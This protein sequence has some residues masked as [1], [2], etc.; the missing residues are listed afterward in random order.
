VPQCN[1]RVCRWSDTLNSIGAALSTAERFA[2]AI[3]PLRK[4]LTIQRQLDDQ[5]GIADT[6]LNLGG[7]L[8]RLG[9]NPANRDLLEEA[10][11]LLE[12]ALQIH[13]SRRNQSG[14]ADVANNLGQV[15]CGYVSVN[16]PHC[17]SGAEL[18]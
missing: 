1:S 15:Q 8:A 5:P 6:S 14:Q 2:E 3:P 11:T 18:P 4:A 13:R 16:G 10:R 9:A 12:E 17:H 7:A